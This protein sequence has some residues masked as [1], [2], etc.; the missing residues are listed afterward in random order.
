MFP[1]IKSHW[2]ALVSLLAQVQTIQVPCY[3]RH[4]RFWPTD[5]GLLQPQ[6]QKVLSCGRQAGAKLPNLFQCRS[7]MFAWLCTFSYFIYFTVKSGIVQQGLSGSTGAILLQRHACHCDMLCWQFASGFDRHT[8]TWTQTSGSEGWSASLLGR[9]TEQFDIPL[10][11]RVGKRNFS[12]IR[13]DCC[14]NMSQID[15]LS[16]QFASRCYLGVIP[17][18]HAGPSRSTISSSHSGG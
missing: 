5:R 16:H 18:S 2:S 8:E 11:L 15:T 10:N 3:G 9:M 17:P 12:Q 14:T 7:M 4:H 1:C 6:H 13:T